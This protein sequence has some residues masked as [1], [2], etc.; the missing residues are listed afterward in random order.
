M[1]YFGLLFMRLFQSYDSGYVFYELT[2]VDQG[3]FIIIV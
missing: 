2:R 1:I 3:C